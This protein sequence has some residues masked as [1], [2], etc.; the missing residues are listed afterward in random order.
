[1]TPGLQFSRRLAIAAGVILP[2]VETARRWGQL[3][4]LRVWPFWLDDF[5]IG[6]F[7]LYGAWQTRAADARGV[8]TLAAAWGFACGMGYSSF[9]GQLAEL[10]QSDPSG[11]QSSVVVAIKGVMM[12]LAIT[13]LIVTLRQPEV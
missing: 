12:L 5:A 13:A 6:G 9:F 11:L 7:L 2:L 8:S 4:E 10:S 3:G 1:V